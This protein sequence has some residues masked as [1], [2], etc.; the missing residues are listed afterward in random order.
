[1]TKRQ[2]ESASFKI[3]EN[4]EKAMLN[5]YIQRCRKL[6]NP[7]ENRR[8]K[9]TNTMATTGNDERNEPLSAGIDK[10][11]MLQNP[12]ELE[13]F[14]GRRGGGHLVQNILQ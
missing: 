13:Q 5:R 10:R 4:D 6:T 2:T 9:M 11:A 3:Y 12:F 8:A 14:S 1:M 7:T